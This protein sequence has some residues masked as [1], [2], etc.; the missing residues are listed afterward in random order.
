MMDFGT[1]AH[2]A[3]RRSEIRRTAAAVHARELARE[4]RQQQ[5]AAAG[6]PER[7]PRTR[8]GD[9]LVAFGSRLAGSPRRTAE[10]AL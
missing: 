9:L 3:Y 4:I 8:L 6:T 7:G 10:P 1:E 2:A 5:L